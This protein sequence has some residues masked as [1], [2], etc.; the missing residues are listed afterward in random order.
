[1]PTISLGGRKADS[2][3]RRVLPKRKRKVTSYYPTDSEPS[4]IEADEDEAEDHE[5]EDHDSEAESARPSKV[6]C[7][8]LPSL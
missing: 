4:D 5:A 8:H 2:A 6:T 3:S 7:L 1:M